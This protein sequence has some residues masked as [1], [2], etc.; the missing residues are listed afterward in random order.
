MSIK[1]SKSLVEEA[2]KKIQTLKLF[3]Q[4]GLKIE[5]QNKKKQSFFEERKLF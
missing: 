3:R 5:L 1:S 4:E 2:L